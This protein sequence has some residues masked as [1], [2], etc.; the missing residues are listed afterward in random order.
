MCQHRQDAGES[1]GERMQ[2]RKTSDRRVGVIEIGVVM[3]PAVKV[4]LVVGTRD[5]GRASSCRAR[6]SLCSAACTANT[7]RV[8]FVRDPRA[9]F[10]R[11]RQPML[12]L[13][14]VNSVLRGRGSTQRGQSV[15]NKS[16][17]GLA[18]FLSPPCRP[19]SPRQCGALSSQ[20]TIVAQPYHS[21]PLRC[22]LLPRTRLPLACEKNKSKS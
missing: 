16:I 13:V 12:S 14:H 9:S 6:R 10:L 3:A 1:P 20:R 2:G 22:A 5:G 7:L 11:A 15:S 19:L 8:C 21:V 17:A 4:T 18:M